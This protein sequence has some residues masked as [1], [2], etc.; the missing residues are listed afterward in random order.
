M[1]TWLLVQAEA[2]LVGV[3]S[4]VVYDVLVRP[5]LGTRWP[6]PKSVAGVMLLVVFVTVQGRWMLTDLAAMMA[7]LCATVAVLVAPS[8]TRAAGML[9]LRLRPALIVCLL[10]VAVAADRLLATDV[11]LVCPAVVQDAAWLTGQTRWPSFPV[12]LVID[13]DGTDDMFV[14]RVTMV[15][16]AGHWRSQVHFGGEPGQEFD[17]VAVADRIPRHQAARSATCHVRKVAG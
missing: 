9:P 1:D 16:G 5:R 12:Q 7:A 3:L 8:I 15:D 6:G 4:N 14:H 13:P 10:M 17:V 11:R 2:I